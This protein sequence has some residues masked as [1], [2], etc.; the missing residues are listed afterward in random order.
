M[1]RS[2]LVQLSVSALVRLVR[3]LGDDT[4]RFYQVFMSS[5]LTF[6][7]HVSSITASRTEDTTC[8]WQ[9]HERSATSA[10]RLNSTISCTFKF[11]AVLHTSNRR[12]DNMF[13]VISFLFQWFLEEIYIY[14]GIWS[15]A[16]RL[17]YMYWPLNSGWKFWF[18]HTLF[19][20]HTQFSTP[21]P[22][23]SSST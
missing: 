5:Y 3:I 9:V 1:V 17:S 15:C 20:K 19:R 22:G 21:G 18:I 13:Q 4:F 14:L 7:E 16:S 2:V 8:H 11:Y 10:Q 6:R 23:F 12:R